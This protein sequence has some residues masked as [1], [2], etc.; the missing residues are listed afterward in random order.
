[1]IHSDPTGSVPSPQAHPDVEA[2][3]G[4]FRG[5]VA[6]LLRGT[7]PDR[8]PR[9]YLYDLI[10]DHLSR[11]GKGLRPALCI[12]TCRAFG[13]STETVLPVAAALEMLH[14]AFLVH[15]DIEDGSEFRRNRPAMYLEQGIPL[16][17]NAG[18]AMQASS[19]RLARQS[20]ERLGPAGSRR[21]LDEFDHLLM[22]S[23]EGQALEI[24][25]VRDNNCQVDA[26]D[27]LLMTLKKTCWYSFI[28]PCRIGAVVARPDDP[29]S[30]E[31]FDRFG[32]FLGVAF[33][34]QDDILNLVGE[35]RTY[36]KEIGG[37]LWEGKRTL[38]LIDVFS[39]AD[40]FESERLRAILAKPRAARVTREIEWI[41]A[42]I[43]KYGSLDHGRRVAQQFAA[44]AAGE[45]EAAYAGARDGDDKEFVRDLVRYVVGRRV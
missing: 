31:R 44:A 11:A 9:R 41:S 19:I 18:D 21:M 1:V 45:L 13:G 40:R 5:L 8:Q 6:P 39:K 32:Y 14:N 17:I 43:R 27:Y 36:G 33:Q 20:A 29:A 35:T 4:E 28:H 10:D 12:A 24:G 42:T 2:R 30:L 37:D 15:D 23:L 22:E 25:W 38:I 26:D 34:I 16:A 7:D 3:L